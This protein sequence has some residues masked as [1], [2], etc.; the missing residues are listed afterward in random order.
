MFS[1]NFKDLFC[2][3]LCILQEQLSDFAYEDLFENLNACKGNLFFVYLNEFNKTSTIF[4][5]KEAGG[6]GGG[7]YDSV[8]GPTLVFFQLINWPSFYCI[9]NI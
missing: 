8:S 4:L 5:I 2:Y 3:L 9:V 1:P 6:G 7:G